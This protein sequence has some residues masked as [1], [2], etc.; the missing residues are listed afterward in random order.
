MKQ[1][2]AVDWGTSTMRGACLDD[3]GNVVEERSFPRGILT[4]E[5]GEFASVFENCFG[6]W[7]QAPDALCLMSASAL[8]Q[9]PSPRVFFDSLLNGPEN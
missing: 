1:L 3:T 7:M 8:D 4:V 9:P 5:P 2:L 6:D